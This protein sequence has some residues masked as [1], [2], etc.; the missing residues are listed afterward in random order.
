MD[1]ANFTGLAQFGY[2]LAPIDFWNLPDKVREGYG[3]GPG[4]IGDLFVPDTFYGLSIKPACEIHDYCYETGQTL[5]DKAFADML[6]LINTLAIIE[7]RSGRLLKVPRTYRAITYYI[8]VRDA[9][10][11]AFGGKT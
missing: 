4:K 2:L 9:G 3:C 1:L 6:F 5:D 8:A 7:H 10:R 11:D